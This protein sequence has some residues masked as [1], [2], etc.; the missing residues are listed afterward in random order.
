[1]QNI[2]AKIII[3]ELNAIWEI[4]N[5]KSLFEY[6]VKQIIQLQSFSVSK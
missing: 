5:I 3:F 6:K 4:N 2:F 1:M